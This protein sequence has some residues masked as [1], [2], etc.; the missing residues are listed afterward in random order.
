[1]FMSA[2]V[3]S[4]TCLY[5]GSQHLI[6]YDM[7]KDPWTDKFHSPDLKKWDAAINFVTLK[8]MLSKLILPA[9]LNF[10]GN[11]QSRTF[12]FTPEC[13]QYVVS[14]ILISFFFFSFFCLNS[15]SDLK[16]CHSQP[17]SDWGSSI[18]GLVGFFSWPCWSRPRLVFFVVRKRGKRE[19]GQVGQ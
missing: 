13:L 7:T 4:S 10:L 18:S 17:V 11:P 6:T 5:V 19:Q 16:Y 8:V 3:C 9:F 1:M 2:F 12:T 14:K 15:S